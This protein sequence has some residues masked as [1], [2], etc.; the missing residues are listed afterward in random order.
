MFCMRASRS[1]CIAWPCDAWRVRLQ[2]AAHVAKLARFGIQLTATV[3]QIAPHVPVV[4]DAVTMI[5]REHG[6]RQPVSLLNQSAFLGQ[7]YVTLLWGREALPETHVAQFNAAV[8]RWFDHQDSRRVQVLQ[9]NRDLTD[10]G[11][12]VR[13]VRNALAHVRVEIVELDEKLFFEFADGPKG[14]PAAVI[15]RMPWPAVG[16]LSEAAT[17]ALSFV[18]YGAPTPP[19]QPR[20]ARPL[21]PKQP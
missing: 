13:T 21:P 9:T 4:R 11:Q 19:G 5:A 16:E 2:E 20:R 12:F 14:H 7:L 10:I 6:V 18:A 17:L 8:G 15:M 1:V 3:D